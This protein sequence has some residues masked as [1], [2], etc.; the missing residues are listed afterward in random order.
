MFLF[1]NVRGLLTHDA[2]KTYTTMKNTFETVGYNTV[3]KVLN[4]WDFGVAQKRERLIT[5]GIRKDYV[6]VSFI[7]WISNVFRIW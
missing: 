3:F 7:Y 5:I 1:E 6:R 2:G 4:A